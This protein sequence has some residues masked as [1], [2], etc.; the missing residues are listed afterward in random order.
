MHAVWLYEEQWTFVYSVTGKCLFVYLIV[1]C[2]C[3]LKGW[4]VRNVGGE[5]REKGENKHCVD[6]ISE[7]NQTE[8]KE[9][10]V[11]EGRKKAEE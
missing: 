10:Y 4:R 6:K 9:K 11:E 8:T 7:R 1:D 2:S 5:G 3:G